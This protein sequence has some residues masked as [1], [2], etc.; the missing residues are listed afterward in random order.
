MCSAAHAAAMLSTLWFAGQCFLSML[1][2]MEFGVFLFFAAWVSAAQPAVLLIYNVR[3]SA[4][5]T[6]CTRD[7]HLP[8]QFV[9]IQ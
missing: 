6:T 9:T 4:A 3:H 1:C 2:A 5:L 8:S 7:H